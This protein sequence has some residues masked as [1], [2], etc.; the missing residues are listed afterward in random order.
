[1]VLDLQQ[2]N[3]SFVVEHLCDSFLL[4]EPVTIMSYLIPDAHTPLQAVTRYKQLSCALC[5]LA[6]SSRVSTWIQV[7]LSSHWLDPAK[8]VVAIRL[9]Q[10][11]PS[12]TSV[13]EFILISICCFV[14]LAFL[15]DVRRRG[16][17]MQVCH[18]HA[19]NLKLGWVYKIKLPVLVNKL[20]NSN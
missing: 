12:S 9:E 1:M 6:R 4:V 8:T 14:F 2:F 17:F 11:R 3:P 15:Q 19:H 20:L 5:T 18:A 7:L 10:R 16:S 13:T